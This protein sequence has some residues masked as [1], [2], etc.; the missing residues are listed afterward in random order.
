MIARAPRPGRIQR[1]DDL[2]VDAQTRSPVDG[3]RLLQF[4][5]DRQDELAGE[6]DAE[7]MT[8]IPGMIRA[9]WESTQPIFAISR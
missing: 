2:P 3:G 5:G 6:E 9:R 4:L 8:R 7:G 1:K